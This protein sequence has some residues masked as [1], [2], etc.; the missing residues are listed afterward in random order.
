MQENLSVYEV[1]SSS[2]ISYCNKW[3][4]PPALTDWRSI[5]ASPYIWNQRWVI[6]LLNPLPRARLSSLSRNTQVLRNV[7]ALLR[8]M[9]DRQYHVF[10]MPPP[11]D[12][13]VEVT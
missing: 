10:G 3:S 2:A 9:Q 13:N 5:S 12:Q 11:H 7:D 4:V 1:P 6:A 8:A